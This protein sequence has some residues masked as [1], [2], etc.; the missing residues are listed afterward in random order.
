MFINPYSITLEVYD[1]DE[2]YAQIPCGA[3]SVY[4]V[5]IQDYGYVHDF[6]FEVVLTK[7]SNG[8][9]PTG[10]DNFESEFLSHVD[11]CL[12]RWAMAANFA[13]H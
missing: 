10:W 8:E 1:L 5:Q 13:Y 4:H 7:V 9:E 6:G 3:E 11:V 12:E 2:F